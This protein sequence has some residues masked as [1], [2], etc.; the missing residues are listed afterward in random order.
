MNHRQKNF[1]LT[2]KST[3]CKKMNSLFVCFVYFVVEI[4]PA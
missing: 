3:K 4:I 1:G 2:T